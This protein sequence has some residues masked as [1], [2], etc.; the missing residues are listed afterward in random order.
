MVY[1]RV[2]ASSC[3]R[4]SGL[5][6]GVG[7]SPLYERG[8]RVNVVNAGMMRGEVRVNV[9]NARPWALSGTLRLFPFHCWLMFRTSPVFIFL[10]LMTERGPYTGARRACY[11]HPFHCWS[12]LFPLTFLPILLKPSVN[13]HRSGTLFQFPFHCWM[14]F[15]GQK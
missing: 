11:T 10:P 12:V 7:L 14:L 4:N 15:R 8:V 9:V 3:V 2:G 6:P 5:Y 13:P 1:T